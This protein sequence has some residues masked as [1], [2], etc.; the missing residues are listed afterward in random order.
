[1]KEKDTGKWKDIPC[2]RLA[3]LTCENDCS[4][5]KYLCIHCNS[6]LN[7]HLIPHRKNLYG[8]TK[9]PRYLNN[10]EQKRRNFEGIQTKISFRAMAIKI[11]L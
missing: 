2:N 10:S 8:T 1:M 4:T 3:E 5:K 7:T 11:T 6:N 9:E